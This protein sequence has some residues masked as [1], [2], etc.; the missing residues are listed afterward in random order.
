MTAVT[1]I[2]AAMAIVCVGIA[3]PGRAAEVAVADMRGRPGKP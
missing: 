3:R 1:A 2:T